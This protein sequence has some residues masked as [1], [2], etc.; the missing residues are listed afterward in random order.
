MGLTNSP[1]PLPAFRFRLRDRSRPAQGSK[2]QRPRSPA[3]DLQVIKEQGGIADRGDVR[4]AVQARVRAL[5]LAAISV[6]DGAYGGRS[7]GGNRRARRPA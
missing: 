5:R 2:V 7:R 3:G 1:A 6:A 4:P